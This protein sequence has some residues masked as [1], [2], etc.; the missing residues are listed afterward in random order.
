MNGKI[1]ITGS[2]GMLGSCLVAKLPNSV[3][4]DIEE[5][6]ICDTAIVK[7]VFEKENP[8]IVIHTAA[9]TDVEACEAERDKTFLVNTVGTQNLVNMCIDQDIL[10]VYISS[11]GVYGSHKASAYIEFDEAMPTTIHHQS[12]RHAEVAIQNHLSKYIILRVGWLFGGDITQNKNFV[13]KRYLEAQNNSVM[14]SD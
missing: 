10:F 11:T 2:K 4:Y 5:F 3:G 7:K 1:L 8:N 14:Y 9:L 12:K 6:D 13:Y